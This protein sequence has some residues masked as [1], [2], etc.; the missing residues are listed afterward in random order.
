MGDTQLAKDIIK[1]G[2]HSTHLAER[3][4]NAI[5]EVEKKDAARVSERNAL[6]AKDEMR[7]PR[8]KWGLVDD[9]DI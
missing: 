3:L 5:Q 9:A 6:M 7:H 1:Y 2:C 4:V 8:S